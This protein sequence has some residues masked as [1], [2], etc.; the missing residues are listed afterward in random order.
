MISNIHKT[1]LSLAVL[2]GSFALLA[3]EV[4]PAHAEVGPT[5]SYGANPIRSFAG[6]ENVGGGY[7]TIL[8]VPVDSNF[9]ITDVIL[10]KS[11]SSVDVCEGTITFYTATGALAYFALASGSDG[12]SGWGTDSINH[13]FTDGLLVPAGETLQV[14][15]GVSC[16]VIYWVISGHYAQQ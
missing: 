16:G 6:V 5:I 13:S 10:T 2:V 3:H 12:N 4:M 15:D 14:Y 7:S 8:D 9:I 11:G 1:I